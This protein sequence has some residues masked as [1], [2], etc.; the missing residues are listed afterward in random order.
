MNEQIKALEPKRDELYK[1]LGEAIYITKVTAA[2]NEAKAD[3]I[4][5]D[6]LALNKQAHEILNPPAKE[7]EEIPSPG[8]EEVK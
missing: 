3:I 7:P 5:R 2:Q 6:L 8:P 1:Q 4:L